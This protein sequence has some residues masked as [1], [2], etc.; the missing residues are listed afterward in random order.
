MPGTHVEGQEGLHS[1]AWGLED[2]IFHISSLLYSEKDCNDFL[3]RG[4]YISLVIPG[5]KEDRL[6]EGEWRR[7]MKFIKCQLYVGNCFGVL[8]Y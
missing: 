3:G 8:N 7:V 4:N 2:S 5:S 6:K 1:R